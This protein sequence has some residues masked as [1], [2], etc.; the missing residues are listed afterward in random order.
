MRRS[1]IKSIA[2]FGLLI[3][4]MFAIAAPAQAVQDLR[5]T[6]YNLNT[7]NSFTYSGAWHNI[8][9]DSY[10][11]KWYGGGEYFEPPWKAPAVYYGIITATIMADYQ[12]YWWGEC[13]SMVKNLAH[14]TVI[15][16]NWYRG[17]HVTDGGVSPGTTIA[18]FVWSPTKGRYVYN[19]GHAAIFREY[20][21]DSYGIINGMIVWDQNWYRNEKG[22]GIVAMHKI[23]KTGYGGT[24]DANS[25]YVIQ[26]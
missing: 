9:A 25:Y 3:V 1:G 16:D 4:A 5:I 12:G 17:G 7:L 13:V 21:Y 8:G 2:V 26:V 23:S 15:T 11:L 18:T 6:D 10:L 19:S 14:S 22:E 24:S 20:T